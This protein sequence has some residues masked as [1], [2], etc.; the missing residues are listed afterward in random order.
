[1]LTLSWALMP[2]PR[3]WKPFILASS[4]L[5]YAAASPP[6][7]LLLAGI[8]LA[9]QLGV[10][11]VQVLRLLRRGDRLVP[12]FAWPRHAP[13]PTPLALPIGLSF[14]TFQAISYVVDTKRGLLTP[15]STLDFALYLSFFPH[16]VA[17]PI[18]RARV[19]PPARPARATRAEADGIHLNGRG[20]GI[21]ADEV[22]AAIRQDFPG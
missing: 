10:W 5:F 3:A 22:L 8:T 15:A 21:A 18:V 4:Y 1:M 12:G 2:H 9:N 14:I 7:A 17:G 16:V 20:A 13:A 19:H 11:T 6:Y